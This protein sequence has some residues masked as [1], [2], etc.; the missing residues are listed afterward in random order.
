MKNWSVE[1]AWP[2]WQIGHAA[3][4]A[5]YHDD[6]RGNRV[7]GRA[8][9]PMAVITVNPGGL[10]SEPWLKAVVRR[11]LLQILYELV[12]CHPAAEIAGNPIARKVRQPADRVEVQTVVA[13]APLLSDVLGPL[14]DGGIYAAR[15]QRRRCR[16]SRRTSTNDD[17]IVH[18]D[19]LLLLLIR[20]AEILTQLPAAYH[21]AA[22]PSTQRSC[23]RLTPS[24]KSV[25]L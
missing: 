3:I 10:D 19:R 20:G 15:P 24:L 23:E 6:A 11:V 8:D 16:Q 2:P 4:P 9:L 7:S 1:C 12:A 21:W 17:D 5:G 25:V 13:G 14:Q 22:T 18:S